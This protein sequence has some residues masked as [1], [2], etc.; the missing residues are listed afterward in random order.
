LHPDPVRSEPAVQSP[1]ARALGAPR[2]DF[3]A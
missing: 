2:C 1:L 3:A